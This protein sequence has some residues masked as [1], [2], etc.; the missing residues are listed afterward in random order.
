MD[1]HNKE[2]VPVQSLSEVAADAEKDH[3]SKV[4]AFT[5]GNKTQA[6]AMLG[7]S[8]KNLWEKIKAYQPPVSG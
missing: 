4:L 8:R 5:K 1:K 6:A 7:I 2:H 3:I